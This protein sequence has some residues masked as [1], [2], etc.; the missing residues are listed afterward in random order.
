[1]GLTTDPK[2]SELKKINSDGQQA[3]YLVLSEEERAKGFVRP[4]RNKYVH[5]GIRPKNPIRDLTPEEHE[6]YDKFG[7]VAYED[8]PE[9]RDSASIGRFWTKEALNSG[10]GS[11][12]KMGFALAETYARDPSFY[13]ATFC[14][15]CGKH[16]P[17]EEFIWRGTQ[18]RVGS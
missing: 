16:F 12:T 14:C 1:M 13:G 6:R 2:D 10:C 15:C 11:E 5:V 8:Y 4:V 9:P 17:V 7:Y 3:V 18:E